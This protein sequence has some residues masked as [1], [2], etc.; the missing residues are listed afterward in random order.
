MADG[1]HHLP[2][3]TNDTILRGITAV[4][5]PALFAL[6]YLQNFPKK[7]E[8]MGGETN[9]S[10]GDKVTWRAESQRKITALEAET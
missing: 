6:Y 8:L 4:L 2:R 9:R 5:R 1:R 3:W 7:G 10:D